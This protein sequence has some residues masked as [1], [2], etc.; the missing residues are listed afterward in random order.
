MPTHTLG[1]SHQL[2]V[3]AQGEVGT[4]EGGR[5]VWWREEGASWSEATAAGR[6]WD[7]QAS[8]HE[9]AVSHRTSCQSSGGH[10]WWQSWHSRGWWACSRAEKHRAAHALLK[11]RAPAA[12][13]SAELGVV[14]SLQGPGLPGQKV[15][16]RHEGR[17]VH[18]SQQAL[19]ESTPS[20]SSGRA[21]GQSA[22]YLPSWT[23]VAQAP[24]G[25]AGVPGRVAGQGGWLG[26]RRYS[27][28]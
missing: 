25:K 23:S 13:L 18:A 14:N 7:L 1:A 21:L 6:G 22:Q 20:F 19:Y 27:R 12:G 28:R 24:A 3:V 11:E 4:R 26:C 9:R 10:G 16:R 8:W 5:G 2:V 15:K 17:S